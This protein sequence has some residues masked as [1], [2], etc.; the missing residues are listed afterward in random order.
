VG[1][2]EKRKEDE[3][4][5]ILS[6]WRDHFSASHRI[7][8]AVLPSFHVNLP[9]S[10]STLSHLVRQVQLPDSVV[11][12]AVRVHVPPSEIHHIVYDAL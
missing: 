5:R 4:R 12:C 11:R 2:G 6:Y 10:T 3:E 1:C 8:S 7:C 9:T